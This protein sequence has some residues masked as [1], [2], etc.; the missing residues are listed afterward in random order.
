MVKLLAEWKNPI[1]PLPK[2]AQLNLFRPSEITEFGQLQK[3]PNL[4]T[5][6]GPKWAYFL[7]ETII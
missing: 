2:V 7:S 1:R 4:M 5:K 3:W 6:V